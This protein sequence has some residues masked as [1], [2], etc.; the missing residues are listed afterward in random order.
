MGMKLFE[1]ETN[2]PTLWGEFSPKCCLFFQKIIISWFLPYLDAVT[3][4][5]WRLSMVGSTLPYKYKKLLTHR[6]AFEHACSTTNVEEPFFPPWYVRNIGHGLLWSWDSFLGSLER[7]MF[8]NYRSYGRNRC[9]PLYTSLNVDFS[10]KSA[11][12]HSK[13]IV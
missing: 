12:T 6:K 7:D 1:Q 5:T 10:L 4:Y 13:L 3:F 2:I 9:K 8:S 11:N